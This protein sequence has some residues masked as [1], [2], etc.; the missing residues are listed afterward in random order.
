VTPGFCRASIAFDAAA[1]C[2]WALPQGGAFFRRDWAISRD[3][4]AI[5]RRVDAAASTFANELSKLAGG[6]G[7]CNANTKSIRD[8]LIH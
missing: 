6:S 1:N 3:Y 5:F 2:D 4:D 7:R 8:L